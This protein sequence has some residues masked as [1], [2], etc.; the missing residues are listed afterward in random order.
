MKDIT[1][2]SNTE[3]AQ[4]LRNERNCA[5]ILWQIDDVIDKGKEL[6]YDIHQDD[7]AEIL[8]DINNGANCEYGITWED[9]EYGIVS[10]YSE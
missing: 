7:A 3:I 5:F 10:F 4:Y 6:D 2:M 8:N 9:I 1:K